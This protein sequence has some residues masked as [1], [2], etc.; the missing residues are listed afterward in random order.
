[1]EDEL[2]ISLNS[3]RNADTGKPVPLTFDDLVE[4]AS[5]HSFL[6]H[7]ACFC[8]I[9]SGHYTA[10]KLF[11]HVTNQDKVSVGCFQYE[12]PGTGCGFYSEY[13]KRIHIYL[14]ANIMSILVD[15]KAKLLPSFDQLETAVYESK[16]L[17]LSE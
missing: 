6:E 16:M 5:T 13:L 17:G 14:S 3:P 1:M 12:G 9:R 8:A 10:V 7:I 11:R 4:Y 2:I 15:L